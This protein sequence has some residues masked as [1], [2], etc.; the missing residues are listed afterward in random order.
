MVNFFKFTEN[1]SYY[2]KYEKPNQTKKIGE[3]HYYQFS[4]KI[5]NSNHFKKFG[6]KAYYEI[7]KKHQKHQKQQ[8]KL[9]ILKITIINIKIK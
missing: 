8:K 2:N 6:G 9:K 4:I 5:K 3:L 7:Q 1:K